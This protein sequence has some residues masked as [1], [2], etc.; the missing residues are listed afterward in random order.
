MP[1]KFIVT[2]TND[3][4]YHFSLQAANYQTIV[5]SR[6]YSSPITCRDGITSV[7]KN[8]SVHVEDQ[9]LQKVEKKGFPKFEMYLDTSGQYRF[10]LLAVNGKI[11]A[12][13]EEGYASKSGCLNG[14]DSVGRTAGEAEI[15]KSALA[16]K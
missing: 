11:I 9:T 15:D 5:T 14:I 6:N 4:Y 8:S 2:K 13:A 12:I 1:G 7:K 10:R 16:K 3:G